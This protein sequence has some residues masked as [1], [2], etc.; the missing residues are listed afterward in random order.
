M[1]PG[2]GK[3]PVA[4]EIAAIV[5]TTDRGVKAVIKETGRT[6]CLPRSIT[7][8][9]PGHAIVPAWFYEKITRCHEKG[10]VRA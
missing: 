6:V 10:A 2:P 7:D 3:K 8:F 9:V 4:I 5:G 1:R